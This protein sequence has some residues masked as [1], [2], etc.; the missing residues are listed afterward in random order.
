MKRIGTTVMAALVAFAFGA[1]TF[2]SYTAEAKTHTADTARKKKKRK[3]KHHS[4][5]ISKRSH[6]NVTAR[7]GSR[8]ERSPASSGYQRASVY[9]SKHDDTGRRKG[10]KK[11]K[12]TS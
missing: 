10:K 1:T 4:A 9:M 2:T 12:H 7:D 6:A 8:A 11:R 3:K 5:S